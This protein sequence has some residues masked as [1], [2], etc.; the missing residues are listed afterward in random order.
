MKQLLILIGLGLSLTSFAQGKKELKQIIKTED[1][2][3]LK[4]LMDQGFDLNVPYSKGTSFLNQSIL[5]SKYDLVK[6]IMNQDNVQ[7][8]TKQRD[9]FTTL[10][11]LVSNGWY[12]LARK[13][14]ESGVDPNVPGYKD[15]H[16]LRSVLFNY[17]WI[18]NSDSSSLNFIKFLFD[19]GINPDLSIS[20]CPKKTTLLVLAVGWTDFPTIEY[21]FEMDKSGLDSTDYWGRT[22]LHYAVMK[23]DIE[24]MNYLIKQGAQL[25]INDNKGKTPLHYALKTQNP[26]LIRE[27]KNALNKSH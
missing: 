1:T 18:D 12:D 13:V 24:V 14:I 27:L 17:T 26:E 15:F 9:G 7:L 22:A 21:F 20:C 16:I 23:E 19:H 25:D 11:Y 4:A 6:F 10:H 8:Q 3:K 2:V 5:H